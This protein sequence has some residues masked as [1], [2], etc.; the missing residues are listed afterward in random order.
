MVGTSN[1]SVPEMAIEIAGCFLFFL[2]A[3]MWIQVAKCGKSEG[4]ISV[5][6]FRK[7]M[8]IFEETSFFGRKD[9][10][11]NTTQKTLQCEAPQL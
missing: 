6:T 2:F 11:K 7:N 4:K 8:W 1:Q 10:S 3:L 9:L 5:A